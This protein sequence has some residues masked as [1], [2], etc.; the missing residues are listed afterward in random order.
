MEKRS[1]N[2][3]IARAEVL[4]Q[5]GS[6]GYMVSGYTKDISTEGLFAE[7]DERFPIGTKMLVV[8]RHP[9]SGQT[10]AVEGRVVH[11]QA[12]GMGIAYKP[13]SARSNEQLQKVLSTL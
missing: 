1:S 13:L 7:V 4:L 5:P 11:V 3:I 6:G 2:R 9:Q 10:A 12:D 8:I